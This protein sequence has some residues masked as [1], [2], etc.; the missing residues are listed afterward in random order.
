[1]QN[2]IKTDAEKTLLPSSFFG[3]SLKL[4]WMGVILAKGQ[5]CHPYTFFDYA[6]NK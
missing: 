2:D 5:L 1:V 4:F 3:Q 6:P